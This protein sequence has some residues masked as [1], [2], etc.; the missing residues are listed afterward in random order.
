[1][2]LM[3]ASFEPTRTRF[4][5]LG[6]DNAELGV[7]KSARLDFRDSGKTVVMS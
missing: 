1:M 2:K 4:D 3:T 7:F 6:R 5:W